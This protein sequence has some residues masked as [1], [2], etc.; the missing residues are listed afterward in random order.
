MQEKATAARH[1]SRHIR[2]KNRV[3]LIQQKA[4]AAQ[5]I[6]PRARNAAGINWKTLFST[7]SVI[8]GLAAAATLTFVAQSKVSF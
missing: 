1:I 2:K 7:G 3:F 6:P 8:A 4:F 5:E